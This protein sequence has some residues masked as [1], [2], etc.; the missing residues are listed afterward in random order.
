MGGKGLYSYKEYLIS[1]FAHTYHLT[2]SAPA[3]H[4]SQVLTL[5]LAPMSSFIAIIWYTS[6]VV[7][8]GYY[9]FIFRVRK[10]K[11]T[12]QWDPLPAVS[13]VI[14]VKNGTAKLKNTLLAL[15]R[16]DYPNY[17]II[18]IDDYSAPS[19]YKALEQ[20]LNRVRDVFFYRSDRAPG[21]N[22]ALRMGVEKASHNIILF[23]D[24]DCIPAGPLWIKS[25]I[26]Q[27]GD[28][29]MV[30]GYSPY[31]REASRLNLF[32]RFETVMTGMQYLSW[33]ML[34][35]PFMGVGRNMLFPKSVLLQDDRITE[36]KKV[37]YGDDDLLV[38]AAAKQSPV[39]V[40]LDP[41]SF[42]FSMPANN[43]S[44][45]IRQKHRHLSAGHFY[46]F[47]SWLKP[48]IFGMGIILHWFLLIP[49]LWWNISLAFNIA[50]FTGII[51]RWIGYATWAKRLGYPEIKWNYVGYEMMYAVYL[52]VMG[53]TTLFRKRKT[54]N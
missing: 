7:I 22:H 54:W 11:A 44:E 34:G 50:F 43:F 6:V 49:M 13:I 12:V 15:T 3:V 14:S 47:A 37:T 35:K 4:S 2:H 41:N 53:T 10:S 1:E 17:E 20:M 33:A 21:K 19:E 45:W 29:G 30:L 31:I 9:L 40:C 32:I 24:D 8:T 48:G 16:Q 52:A 5:H 42:L 39:S 38:Q 46:S 28:G 18:I 51:L 36:S 25:M 27:S 26:N 23:T